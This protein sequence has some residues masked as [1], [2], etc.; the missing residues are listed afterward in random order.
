M[1]NGRG[2]RGK[3]SEVRTASE[4]GERRRKKGKGGTG[5]PEKGGV[6]GRKKVQL[7]KGRYPGR[8]KWQA[9]TTT[10]EQVF[11]TGYQKMRLRWRKSCE[12]SI[13]YINAAVISP[14]TQVIG[15]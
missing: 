7:G 6:S 8:D 13:K 10:A 11:F 9:E 1:R 12:E 2:R 15:I 3:N 4:N 5:K 14:F